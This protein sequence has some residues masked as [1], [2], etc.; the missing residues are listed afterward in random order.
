M[1]NPD[2]TVLDG[3]PHDCEPV[4]R[5]CYSL[6]LF[7]TRHHYLEVTYAFEMMCAAPYHD[8]FCGVDEHILSWKQFQENCL[9]TKKVD[10]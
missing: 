10:I 8:R 2:N 7:E 3:L 1:I 5:T 9:V 4:C 6:T